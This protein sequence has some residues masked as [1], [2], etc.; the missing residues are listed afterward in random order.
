ME[1]TLMVLLAVVD[2]LGSISAVGRV[3]LG[4]S[5]FLA[6]LDRFDL[7][8]LRILAVLV[9]N[10]VGLAGRADGAPRS[11]RR[12]R[13]D[14]QCAF[15]PWPLHVPRAPRCHVACLG[16]LADGAY[17][18]CRVAPVALHSWALQSWHM[19]GKLGACPWF[20]RVDTKSNPVDGLSRGD[21]QGPW[22]PEPR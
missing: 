22:K 15:Q 16:G 1:Q 8:H 9:V 3:S 17:R 6:V 20:D 2:V 11:C 13:V 12:V 19:V 18:S 14:V 5:K 21:L 10:L 7:D 4:L